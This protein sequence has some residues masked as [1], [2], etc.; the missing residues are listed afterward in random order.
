MH[1]PENL[2]DAL[3]FYQISSIEFECEPNIANN[4]LTYF[5][6]MFENEW[7]AAIYK[8]ND[9]LGESD[10]VG[11]PMCSKIT[12]HGFSVSFEPL[13]I[14][15]CNGEYCDNEYGN[16]ALNKALLMLK[17]QY[18]DIKYEGYIGYAW[19]D[20][21]GGESIEYTLSSDDDGVETA[22]KLYDSIGKGL[23]AAV[24]DEEFW[25]RLD[26]VIDN[27]GA[28]AVLRVFFR[29]EKWLPD[30]AVDK[31]LDYA[32]EYEEGSR[33][34]LEELLLALENGNESPFFETAEST[35]LQE[36]QRCTDELYAYAVQQGFHS[37]ANDS[38]ALGEMIRFVTEK[39]AHGDEEAQYFLGR[40]ILAT[41]GAR[42]DIAFAA[43]LLSESAMQGYAPAKEYLE[44]IGMS[45]ESLMSEDE[46][47][48]ED[49]LQK[50]ENGDAE[51]Q[52]QIA[53]SHMSFEPGEDADL[54]EA[55]KWLA[56]AS[57][58]GHQ[59]AANQFRFWT[60][61]NKLMDKSVLPRN[62]DFGV[63]MQTI[64]GKAE[65]G[66]KEAHAALE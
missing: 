50:A 13:D 18:P 59:M 65:G 49:M 33:K 24:D 58:N 12:E 62:A 15:Y 47:D 7:N 46:V 27:D 8:V 66:D 20:V 5:K 11:V 39:A 31:L 51:A 44:Q 48:W 10:D 34:E 43:Q 14:P 41:S 28:D 25:D 22:P 64:I 23:A 40:Y 54:T 9:E 61:V 45:D 2:I 4:A 52:Y 42:E 32:E 29:Y 16:E 36:L 6:S 3:N 30:D 57:E 60:Y 1:L 26:Y 63:I 17:E 55:L 38:Q 53:L 19:S 35:G 37:N 21:H 56:K